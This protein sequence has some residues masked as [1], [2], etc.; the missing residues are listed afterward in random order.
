[1][2][3][4]KVEFWWF[5]HNM[6]AHPLSQILWM[7]SLFGLIKPISEASDW[8]HDWTVPDHLPAEGRG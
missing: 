6:I 5:V 2:K 1:M 7:I 4:V 3:R 8:V